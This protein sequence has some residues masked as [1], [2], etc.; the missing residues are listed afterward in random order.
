VFDVPELNLPLV[1]ALRRVAEEC[2]GK[3]DVVDFGGSLG[4][5]WWQNRV[6]LSEGVIARWRVVEQP[7]FVSAGAEFSDEVLTFHESIDTAVGTADPVLILFSSVLSYLQNPRKILADANG[8][9]FR[10]IVIDRTPILVEG[11]DQLVVQHTPPELGGGS[12]PAWLFSRASLLSWLEPHYRLKT[13][14]LGFEELDRRVQYRGFHFE[15]I[16]HSSITAG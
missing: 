2:G 16:N 5:T 8:R 1:S 15:R 7:H 4:S 3:L 10:F 12:Y 11:S 13:E 14:W 9:G 6:A